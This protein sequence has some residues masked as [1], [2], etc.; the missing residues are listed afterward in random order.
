[1]LTTSKLN[2]LENPA[3]KKKITNENKES[4]GSI[5]VELIIFTVQFTHN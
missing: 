4:I 1:M 3:N 5:I 2:I